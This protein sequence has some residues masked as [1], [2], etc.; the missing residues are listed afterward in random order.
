MENL[1]YTLIQIFHNFGAAAVIG[2]SA[3]GLWGSH[4]EVTT[5]RRLF[6]FAGIGWLIQAVSGPSFGVASI[7]FHGSLPDI[8]GIAVTAL[9]IK[10]ICVVIGLLLAATLLLKRGAGK[11][12]GISRAKFAGH[13]TL[14]V[15]AL[16]AAAFL[17]WY[18]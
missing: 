7:N 15:V 13:F 8:Y 10:I 11:D 3:A 17:R 18:S 6:F 12:A 5:Q 1:V 2:F 16:T 4:M 9:S 14:G